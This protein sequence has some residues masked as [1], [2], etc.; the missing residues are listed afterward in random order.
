MFNTLCLV[1]YNNYFN[2]IV[3]REESFGEY[4]EYDSFV[5]PNY[6]FNPND[7]IT[8]E[9]IVNMY[10]FNSPDY[11]VVADVNNQIE[12]RWFIMDKTR[13]RANQWKLSLRRD[14]MADYIPFISSAPAFIEKATVGTNDIAIFNS[15][16][17]S[18]NQ[19]KTSQ[20]LIKDN[21]K[22]AWLCI[23]LE[24]PTEDTPDPM[25]SGSYI[26]FSP[27]DG[28]DDSRGIYTVNGLENM[29]Y[30]R[31]CNLNEQGEPVRILNNT[32]TISVNLST[33]ISGRWDVFEQNA[34]IWKDTFNYTVDNGTFVGRTQQIRQPGL[35]SSCAVISNSDFENSQNIENAFSSL[36]SSI[37]GTINRIDFGKYYNNLP[38][39]NFEYIFDNNDHK[40]YQVSW[41]LAGQAKETHAITS[42]GNYLSLYNLL[43]NKMRVATTMTYDNTTARNQ[44]YYFNENAELYTF[45]LIEVEAPSTSVQFNI[46]SIGR[47]ETKDAIY[48]VLAIPYGN[49]YLISDDD[50]ND[51][52]Y[53]TSYF[54]KEQSLAWANNIVTKGGARVY[55]AQ[56]LP[57]CPIPDLDVTFSEAGGL[58]FTGIYLRALDSDNP[59]YE[60]LK[61]YKADV[62]SNIQLQDRI[63]DI[64]GIAFWVQRSKFSLNVSTNQ[65]LVPEKN[66]KI[67]NECS[68]WRLNSPNWAST[69]EFN[70]VKN[71]GGISSWNIDCQ[72]KP[73][74]PYINLS[75]NFSGLY[76]SNFNDPRGLVLKGDFSIPRLSDAWVE[77]ELNNKNY[78]AIFNRQM[79]SLEV[80]NKIQARQDIAAATAGTIG[81]LVSGIAAGTMAFGG[82]GGAIG[83]AAGAIL[84]GGAGLEDVLANR[85]LREENMSLQRDLYGY[86]LQNIKARPDTLTNVGAFNQD[87]TIW[88]S[89][90]YYTC[91]EQEKEALRNKIKY[92]GMTVMRIGTIDE[93]RQLEPTFMKGQFIRFENF[94]DDYHVAQV[95]REEFNTGLFI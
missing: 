22:L 53:V 82:I 24:K 66:W 8:T 29:P 58:E 31:Y 49:Y 63:K 26:P 70:V 92:N 36:G 86:N 57:Y 43:N 79:D 12:S 51:D 75:P 76:G 25:I 80:Q 60:L 78:E 1:S 39:L 35:A 65:I 11:L 94:S 52:E 44:T 47:K 59:T 23:Y 5:I 37:R 18:F 87:N 28:V 55:D 64:Y 10:D 56:L 67:E 33:K 40:W 84:S 62:S 68:V 48:D 42:T 20:E 89:L 69:F 88:P 2:R 54:T 81:G 14:V 41:K 9:A 30:Y 19:I 83:G 4:L 15:E 38:V 71:G 32:S 21:S 45:E 93:F 3:K 46:R 13:I 17:M 90:E 95:I 61:K 34:A 72:Y 73:F 6:N 74:N 27:E 7:E 91:S 77:Y 16:N 85:E 50:G